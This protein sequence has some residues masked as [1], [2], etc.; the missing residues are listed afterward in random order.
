MTSPQLPWTVR[1]VAEEEWA[2]FRDVDAHAFGVAMEP[3]L[4][5][6]ERLLHRG[7]RDIGAYDA[8]E[9]VGIATAYSFRLGVPGAV[10]PAAGV[11]W[12]G[13]LPTHRRRG[14]LRALMTNQ[15]EAV[16]DEGTEPLAILWASEPEI[17]GRFGYGL[18]S[19]AF[20]M[21]VPRSATAL[22]ASAPADPGLRLRLAD[23][24]AWK[25]LAPVYDALAAT[26]P[27]L[28]LRD[29]AWWQRTVRDFASMRGGRSPLRCVLAEDGDGLRGYALYATKQ[30]WDENF[31]KGEV[32][33]RE[34]MAVDPA[35]RAALYRYLFDL[36]L[37]GS[38]QLSHV[39]V[40]DP[41]LHWLRN[42]RHAKPVLEDC[43]YV[44]VVDLPR[45]LTG[46]SYATDVD[47]VLDVSDRTC[48][49]NAGTWRLTAT[50]GPTPDARC[51]QTDDEA[52]ISLDVVHL[53]AAYLGGTA[54]TE[55]A[56][57]G[58]PV[59]HRPGA[60]TEVTAA[61]AHFPA[62]WTPWVF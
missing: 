6:S 14:V 57:A 44:R 15:L 48:P 43:L 17:Y 11:S 51:E 60:L 32:S 35:A 18:A 45:A 36:D 33:V 38:A 9:L 21:T 42:T 34:V 4:E 61:F 30:F 37:M 8:G 58:G 2:A 1:P 55:L 23:P 53:G 49:W 25:D 47:V 16:H 31:G 59:E 28:P 3:E 56:L 40:D 20:S 10:L 26:R 12:V 13:V 41:L 39:A 27:G 19:R 5:E 22:H 24:A 62:P 29:D 50:G 52:D 46:R 54:L 7:A